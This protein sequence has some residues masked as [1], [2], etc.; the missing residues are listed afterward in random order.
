MNQKFHSKPVLVGFS[1]LALAALILPFN[2]VLIAPGPTKNLL[3]GTVS[4]SNVQTNSINDGALYSTTIYATS[5]QDR[6]FGFQV[7]VAWLSGDLAVFPRDA[8]YGNEPAKV[9]EKKEKKEMLNSQ[10]AAAE[11][12][13]AFISQIPNYPRQSWSPSDVKVSMKGVGGGS[14]GL[15]FALTLI[16]KTVDPELIGGRKIAV[17][18]AISKSGKVSEI[19]GVDQ[20]ILGA[21]KA[22]AKMFI[23]PRANCSSQTKSPKG[24]SIYA[25]RNLSEAVHLLALSKSGGSQVSSFTCSQK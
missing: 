2:F 11:A 15:A 7:L 12:A 19:G 3:N 1:L 23:M 10:S 4:I 20:K 24:M 5:P 13:L 18:G 17:T 16:T 8:V 9:S 22:G 21:K 6:P 14:A 25:V